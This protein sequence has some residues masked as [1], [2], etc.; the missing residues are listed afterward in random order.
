M[1]SAVKL[2]PSYYLTLTPFLQEK[3]PT[4]KR[5]QRLWR[6]VYQ[7]CPCLFY[8]IFQYLERQG[9]LDTEDDTHTWCLHYVYLPMLN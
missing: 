3:A 2:D 4:T 7:G 6:D 1:S 8:Q 5:I 9:L